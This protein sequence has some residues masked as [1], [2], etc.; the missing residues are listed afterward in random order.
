MRLLFIFALLLGS[1]SAPAEAPSGVRFGV[2]TKFEQG[3]F[4]KRSVDL[5][6]DAGVSVNRDVVSWQKVERV[7]GRYDWSAQNAAV[8]SALKD[9]G[10]TTALVLTMR[11]DLYDDGDF[12]KSSA[13][14]A[15][16]ARFAAHVAEKLRGQTAAFEIGNEV[17]LTPTARPADYA[18]L[19]VAAAN[20]I[21]AIDRKV[22]V[23]ADPAIFANLPATAIPAQ[24]TAVGDAARSAL[25][26]AD[27]VVAHQY[28]YQR[29]G[30]TFAQTQAVMVTAMARR[31]AWLETLAGRPVPLYVT[32]YGWP[33]SAQ[34]GLNAEEQARQLGVTTRA[35]AALPFVKIAIVYELADSCTDAANVECT[36][37]L[38]ARGASGLVPKPALKAFR[39]AVAGVGR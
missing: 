9:R 38:Y 34:R 6:H 15:A 37:G 24:G 22:A 33:Q 35:L 19:F 1:T 4:G 21:H 31:A 27:G 10:I 8:F 26:V 3:M 28:P 5:I 14:V 18:A 20:A 23:V 16:F 2:V 13:A 39:D 32:E 12:P 17:R 30:M 36:F 11:N 29:T 25:R 7:R